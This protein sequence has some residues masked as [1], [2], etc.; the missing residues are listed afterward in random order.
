MKM[1]SITSP[2]KCSVVLFIGSNPSNAS[3]SDAAFHGSTKSSQILTGWLAN[4]PKDRGVMFINVLNKKTEDNRPLKKSEVKANL[5]QLQSTITAIEPD[6]I[7]TLGKTADE[8]LTLL[9]R[10]HYAMP[11]PSGRNRLLNDPKYVEGKLKGL[12]E[13]T[14]ASPNVPFNIA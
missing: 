11:H 1:D 14:S 2:T 5:E 12:T 10:E 4:L 7:V 13:Y 8:A 3:S 9:H 6:Y